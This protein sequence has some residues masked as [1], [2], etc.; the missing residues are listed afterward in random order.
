MDEK[1]KE[2]E[3]GRKWHS[4]KYRKNNIKRNIEMQNT[5]ITN[6]PKNPEFSEF[7]IKNSETFV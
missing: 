5:V 7:I 3:L 2:K 1:T 6:N 4:R